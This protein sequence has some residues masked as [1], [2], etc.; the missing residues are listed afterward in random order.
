[1]EQKKKTKAKKCTTQ[2]TLGNQRTFFL[3][4]CLPNSNESSNENTLA[5][6]CDYLTQS[7][8]ECQQFFTNVFKFIF[9]G[10]PI[11]FISYQITTDDSNRPSVSSKTYA[12]SSCLSC[13][14]CHSDGSPW[15]M[16]HFISPS[17]VCD[18]F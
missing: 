7:A 15:I 12:W 2:E 14:C 8:K 11:S 3:W 4:S 6:Y 18:T 10:R 13:F 17:K 16:I 5:L 9:Q 1:M